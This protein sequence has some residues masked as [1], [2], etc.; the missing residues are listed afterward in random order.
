MAMRSPRLARLVLGAALLAVVGCS[1]DRD[2]GATEAPSQ[3]PV[4]SPAGQPATSRSPWPVAAARVD[5]IA[6]R[7][8][9]HASSLPPAFPP[10]DAALPDLLTDL[11]GRVRMAY[12]PRESFDDGGGWHTERVFFLG[13]DGAWRALEL[14][15]LG[16]PGWSHPGVDT[17]GAGALSP[18]GSTW[19][20]PSRAGIVL[21]DLSAGRS[22][23]VPVPGDHTR[24]LAWHPGSRSVDV[25][26]LHG[27]S[28]QRTWSVRT[29]S[30]RVT[31]APY[32]V[33]I[34][35]FADDGSVVTFTRRG[36]H[37]LRTV[38][39]G[40][41]QTSD[42]VAMPHRHARRGGAVGHDRILFGVNREL[43]VVDGRSGAPMARLRLGPGDAAGWPRGWWGPDTAWFYEAGRG[44]VTWNVTNGRTRVLTR[45]RPPVDD[46]LYWSTSVAVDLMR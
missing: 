16:L 43:L 22:R 41:S 1:G 23:I 3:V 42:V 25:M 37:T 6:G 13:V 38:H 14:A 45:V 21:V 4:T 30:L 5:R 46:T 39:R 24:Y 12:H 7:L 34:D 18:D 44:L 9:G 31:R 10:D 17:Y 26:R 20:A 40:R 15:D 28:T 19:A 2:P 11:P 27:A 32:L 8:S 29:G 35:G 33:P 36:G